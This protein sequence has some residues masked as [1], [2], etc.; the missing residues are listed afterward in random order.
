MGVVTKVGVIPTP[1]RETAA[2][3]ILFIHIIIRAMFTILLLLMFTIVSSTS[4]VLPVTVLRTGTS[5]IT[6]CCIIT[7]PEPVMRVPMSIIAAA[8]TIYF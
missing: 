8:A 7:F 1:F 5:I 2:V 6:V 4:T 3:R